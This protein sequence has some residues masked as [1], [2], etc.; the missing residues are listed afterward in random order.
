LLFVFSPHLWV[1]RHHVCHSSRQSV[2]NRLWLSVVRAVDSPQSRLKQFAFPT[3]QVRPVSNMGTVDVERYTGSCLFTSAVRPKP[4]RGAATAAT[5]ESKLSKNDPRNWAGAPLVS[6][7][8]SIRKGAKSR[9]CAGSNVNW[10]PSVYLQG[11]PLI[12]VPRTSAPAPPP[13]VPH[14]PRPLAPIPTLDGLDGSSGISSDSCSVTSDEGLASG[15]SET[16]LPRI[17]KPRKR[18]KKERKLAFLQQQQQQQQ[19]QQP[20]QQSIATS[21]VDLLANQGDPLAQLFHSATLDPA[22]LTSLD[23]M[24]PPPLWPGLDDDIWNSAW[25]PARPSSLSPSWSS[26]SSSRSSYWPDPAGS[27]SASYDANPVACEPLASSGCLEVSSQ[28]M[29]SPYGH[30][31]I[32]IRFFSSETAA[33]PQQDP[34]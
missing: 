1:S 20:Q 28:I 2:V 3:V 33:S 9:N 21:G 31:D 7:A 4:K 10:Y 30:R 32:E 6:M 34:R 22:P 29:T 14:P 23:C 12:R 16:C 8:A 13:A 24:T 27:G 17:I 25:Y 11:A 5:D 19:Q 15:G 18:R 26:G